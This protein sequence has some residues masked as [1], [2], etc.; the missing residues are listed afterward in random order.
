MHTD[1]FVREPLVFRGP[2]NVGRGIGRAGQPWV[3][4]LGAHASVPGELIVVS[5]TRPQRD[6]R[7]RHTVGDLSHE[8]TL[9]HAGTDTA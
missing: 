6:G 2:I 1:C 9:L 8:I 7:M 5:A 4:P 3:H